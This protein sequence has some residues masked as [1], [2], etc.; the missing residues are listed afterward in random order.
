MGEDT[1]YFFGYDGGV[2]PVIDLSYCTFI[3]RFCSF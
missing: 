2:L 3:E 1:L